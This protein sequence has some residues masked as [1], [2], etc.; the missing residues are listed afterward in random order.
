MSDSIIRSIPAVVRRELNRMVS[1]PIYLVGSVGVMLFCFVF[2]FT[3]F[4][5]GMPQRLPIGVID[6]DDSY[7]SRALIRNVDALPQVH[8]SHH[9]GSYKEARADMQRGKIYAFI[10]IGPHFESDLLSSRRPQ[11]EY[12]VNQTYLIAGSLSYKDLTYISELGSGYLQQRILQAKG[13]VGDEVTMPLLQPVALDVHSIGNPY[14]NYGIYLINVLLPG[15]LQ[16][17]I[18]MLT[19]FSIGIEF[20]QGTTSQW[21]KTAGESTVVALLGKALPYTVLFSILGI[22]TDVLLFGYM[23][24]P[25]NG[26]IWWMFLATILYVLAY[27][28][29]GVF[30]IG[31]FR[32]LRDAISLAAFY[33]LFAF[34]FAGFTFPIEGLPFRSQIFSWIFPIRYYFKNYVRDALYGA[35]LS[36][37]W[38]Y[39]VAMTVFML[40]PFIVIKS[41]REEF[42]TAEEIEQHA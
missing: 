33:G 35:P 31:I 7:V 6:Q 12:Y 26:S 4:E 23:H 28:A 30:F 19:V 1:R 25:M 2:F 21:Y 16:L 41:L 5:E 22:I 42:T 15:V 17:C 38:W 40:L 10:E 29:V 13:I 11:I 3:F 37:S 24:F 39:L 20:K 9:Y 14:T 8:V 18:L 36:Y 32:R 27:Q 34:T